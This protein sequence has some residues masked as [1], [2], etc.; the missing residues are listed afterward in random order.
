MR[1]YLELLHK[2]DHVDV[3]DGDLVRAMVDKVMVYKNKSLEFYFVGKWRINV[4]F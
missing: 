3:F 1:N 4:T 2:L